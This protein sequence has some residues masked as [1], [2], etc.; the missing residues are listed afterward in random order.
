MSNFPG[1]LQVERLG[2]AANGRRNNLNLI[3][4]V[5]AS[6][7]I[8][9]HCWVIRSLLDPVQVYLKNCNL[10]DL[11]VRAFFL[12]SGYLIL[13]SGARSHNAL[14]YL[15]ARVLRIFPALIVAVL[16]SVFLLGPIVTSL[17]VSAYFKDPQSWTYL[18]EL[19]LYKTSDTLP[20]VFMQPIQ[21]HEVNIVLW[22]L[23]VEWTMYMIVMIACLVVRRRNFLGS[24]PAKT[25]LFIAAALL[26]TAQ[27]M[28]IEHGGHGKSWISY[29]IVGSLCYL[30]RKWIPLSIPVAFILVAVEIGLILHAGSMTKITTALMPVALSYFLLV[31]GF[32]PALLVEPF[33]RLGDY[34]YGL[35]IFAFPIQQICVTLI[36]NSPWKL[37]AACYP[38]SLLIAVLSWHYIEKSCLTM[39]DRFKRGNV[40]PTL[41]RKTA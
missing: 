26:L 17:S 34:S 5:A 25:L 38:P 30:L 41:T 18:R 7:V 37:F 14:Q 15:A 21:P 19:I 33:L 40:V 35:Y 1:F 10:G 36:P 4:F 13:Q 32:H 9:S 11:S 23:P 16:V 12:L 3:R 29:F 27:M 8:L 22:T 2:N 39:R 6:S 24:E 31:F 28:P 20:G